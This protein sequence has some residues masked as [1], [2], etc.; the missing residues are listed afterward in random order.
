[1]FDPGTAGSEFFFNMSNN[2]V[3]NTGPAEPP[4]DGHG[5]AT[6][7]RVVRGMEVL[8]AIQDL[9]ADADVDFEVIKGQILSEQVT[10]TNMTLDRE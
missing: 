6:F 8:D 4:R 3:L 7:G 1:R 5:Y 9:P 10:I 2:T